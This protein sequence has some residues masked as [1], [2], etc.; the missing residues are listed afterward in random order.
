MEPASAWTAMNP[1]YLIDTSNML[2]FMHAWHIWLGIISMIF[3]TLALLTHLGG[4]K[5][6]NLGLPAVVLWTILGIMGIYLGETFVM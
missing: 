1:A 6:C 4:W 5:T 3:G 2:L